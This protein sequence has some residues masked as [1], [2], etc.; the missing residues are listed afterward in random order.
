MLVDPLEVIDGLFIWQ[1]GIVL[2]RLIKLRTSLQLICFLMVYI[3]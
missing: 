1:I 2:E 3:Y